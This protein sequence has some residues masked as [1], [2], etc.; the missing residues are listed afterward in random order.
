MART[1]FVVGNWKMNTGRHEAVRLAAAIASSN[2]SGVDLT[3][4]PPF[5]WLIPVA[6][7]LAGCAVALGAQDCWKEMN[8]AYTGAVS[9]AMLAELCRYVI[10]GHSERRTIFGESDQLVAEKLSAVMTTGLAPIICV[11]EHLE[12]RQS[13]RA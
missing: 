4:C 2:L 13:G 8:G 1:P 9:A 10:I 5:P 11:G 7:A 6:D 12:T 3:V